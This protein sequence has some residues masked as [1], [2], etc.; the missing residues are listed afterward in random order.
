VKT[1]AVKAPAP[2]AVTKVTA[3]VTNTVQ[4]TTQKVA[5]PVSK[6][7]GG[8]V[9]KG[10]QTGGK[11][12]SKATGGTTT[13][14]GG[15]G[16][17]SVASGTSG[18]GLVTGTV[19][20][21][22][23][24]VRNTTGTAGGTLSQ[25]GLGGTSAG[26]GL[27]GGT[28][29]GSPG[30]GALTVLGGPGGGGPGGVGG[31]GTGGFGGPGGGAAAGG[32]HSLGAMLAGASALQLRAVLE[33]LQGCIPALPQRDRRV[34]SMRAGLNGATPMSRTQVATQLGMSRASVRTVERRALNRLQYAANTT[35][36]AASV[37]G[38]FDP[39]GVG[40]LMPQLLYAG[41]VPVATKDAVVAGNPAAASASAGSGSALLD[42]NG[43]AQGGPAW[44]I[45]LFTVLL[46][47]SI[48]A[49]TRELRSNI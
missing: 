9:S 10:T 5:Q 18:G 14:S 37:V 29:T 2:K 40:S 12:I 36:C 1:P 17:G 21:V 45:V 34:I 42:L 47:V 7:T 8:A 11:T 41:A 22:L 46:S 13:G 48:A 28:S 3:P 4:K 39:T 44:M 49:L 6:T 16:G 20:S 30:A 27:L 43:G 38:P 31:A 33:E 24:G 15:G 25:M 32:G 23:G 35:G 26:G 19:G